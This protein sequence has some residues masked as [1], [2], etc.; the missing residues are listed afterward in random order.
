VFDLKGRE[1]TI[2]FVGEM[3][4]LRSIARARVADGRSH[5]KLN[6]KSRPPITKLGR[7]KEEV[8]YWALRAYIRAL[9]MIGDASELAANYKR[10]EDR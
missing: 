1:M 8:A 10:K 9:M 6:V 4:I 5:R 7:L 2:M 3:V